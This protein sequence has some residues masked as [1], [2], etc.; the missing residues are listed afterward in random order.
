VADIGKMLS[1]PFSGALSV[2]IKD[3]NDAGEK[4]GSQFGSW[5]GKKD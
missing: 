1:I 4:Y 5:I 2:N 3:Y